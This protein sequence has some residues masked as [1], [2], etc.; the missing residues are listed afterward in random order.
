[1]KPMLN[2][3]TVTGADDSI[4]PHALIAIAQDFPFVEFGILLSATQIGHTRFPSENWLRQLIALFR[5]ENAP[6]TKRVGHFAGHI[7]GRW[8]REI[9]IGH[10]PLLPGGTDSTALFERWQLNTHAQPHAIDP[11]EFRNVFRRRWDSYQCVILQY[12]NVNAGDLML[13][14]GPDFCDKAQLLFDLSHGAGV[15]PAEWPLPI[16]KLACGY[17]GGLSPENVAEQLTKL[18]EIIPDGREIWIDAE[19]HL[20]S[21]GDR[22]FDL[23]K[24]R[25]FLEAARPWVAAPYCVTR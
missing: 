23:F 7:C 17:A 19:T 9:L 1:M 16:E 4:D 5:R 6:G 12:D 11:T 20:R 10:W 22:Q 3:V 14:L 18:E 15:L 2:K 21:D 13:A 25:A 24:V 8:V